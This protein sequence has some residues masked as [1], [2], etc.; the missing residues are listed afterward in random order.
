MIDSEIAW[1]TAQDL[2]L[3]SVWTS[4]QSF[5]EHL[6]VAGCFHSAALKLDCLPPQADLWS[7]GAILFELVTGRPPFGGA[8]HVQVS[9]AATPLPCFLVIPLFC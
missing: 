7:V 3:Y 6:K 2:S 5:V 9:S 8:N 4:S 1:R